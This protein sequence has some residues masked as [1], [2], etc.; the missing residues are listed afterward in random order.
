MSLVLCQISPA[1][2]IQ[3]EKHV[4]GYAASSECNEISKGIFSKKGLG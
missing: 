2:N 3:K 4:T 1:N